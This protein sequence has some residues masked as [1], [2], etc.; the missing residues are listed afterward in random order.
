[1]NHSERPSQI[2]QRPLVSVVIPTWNDDLRL[3]RCLRA[4]QKQTYPEDRYEVIVVNDSSEEISFAAQGS[5]FV[6]MKN[7]KKGPYSARNLGVRSTRGKI[8]FFTDSDCVPTEDWLSNGVDMIGEGADIIGGH[9]E[10]FAAS[11]KPTFVEKHQM[12]FAFR[13][14][15]NIERKHSLPTANLVIDRSTF[16][17][18]GP[19]NESM[20]SGADYEWF[21]RALRL[22]LSA[23]YGPHVV[24]AHPARRTL[25]ELMSQRR[26]FSSAFTGLSNRQ[27][28][29][30]WVFN[31][32]TQRRRGLAELKRHSWLTVP[33]KMVLFALSA[34][35]LCY[36]TYRVL[37]EFSRGEKKL[38]P[39]G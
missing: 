29:R 21:L 27:T 15:L 16:N 34:F 7:N 31:W 33:E 20:H 32:L 19:F 30:K 23:S 26:R 12:V 18:V 17:R 39:K 37:I 28:Q 5:A 14:K 10:V 1:M 3:E 11:E 2:Q 35:L 25:A 13:Q 24:V 9:I 4:L 22:G 38:K 8:L 36:Q 6:F